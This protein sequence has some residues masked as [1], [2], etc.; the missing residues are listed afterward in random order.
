MNADEPTSKTLPRLPSIDDAYDIFNSLETNQVHTGRFP[1][2]PHSTPNTPAVDARNRSDSYFALATPST[3]S[4]ATQE[5]QT[6]TGPLK[7]DP[8]VL[9][10]KL[11]HNFQKIEQSLYAQ[12]ARTPDGCL[13]DVR[14]AFL[15]TGKGTR[16][17]LQAWQKKHLGVAKSKVVGGLIVDEPEWWGK[18]WH[19]LPGVNVV[20]RDDDWGSII[21]HTLSTTNYQL[22]LANLSMIRTGSGSHASPTP[23]ES[24][25]SSFFSVATGY[26]LFSSS[27]KNHPDP[28]QEDVVWNEP[29]HF[30]AVIS[31]KDHPR[32]P[33]SILSIRDVLRQ[34][35]NTDTPASLSSTTSRF[36]APSNASTA[37]IAAT[38]VKSKPDVALNMEFADGTLVSAPS[39]AAENVGVLILQHHKSLDNAGTAIP[40]PVSRP[41][42]IKSVASSGSNVEPPAPT[43][44]PQLSTAAS[45]ISTDTDKSKDT[46]KKPQAAKTA[47]SVSSHSVNGD[48]AEFQPPPPPP[49]DTIKR[50]SSDGRAFGAQHVATPSTSST[51]PSA[52]KT[53]PAT[54]PQSEA[55]TPSST[56]SGFVSNLAHGINSAM[57]LVIP[58]RE[59][60]S[61]TSTPST[62]TLKKHHAL[63]ADI[64]TFDERPHIKYDWTV[65]KR[66]KFSCT[67]YYAKQFDL[68][69]KRY[70]I[71]DTFLTSLSRSMN[72]A[73]TGGKS[74]SNF[75]KTT[76][77]QF[78]IKTLVNAWNVADL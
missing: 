38:P 1:F 8:E 42:S 60:L 12:L 53:T 51:A 34:K 41:V 30:S 69:R 62:S 23:A 6:P 24:T 11:R 70:G 39:D 78:I 74:K 33:T 50:L 63:L 32:D 20:V 52:W 13:N 3:V 17:R 58:G 31:R 26:K 5:S 40:A 19:V 46:I 67:V 21:A 68:L 75:W 10:S 49:K 14:R 59:P 35:A 36:G 73:A 45:V 47:S 18:S 29:E 56:T 76:D 44:E 37:P 77:D 61:R 15:A 2:V 65:G 9:L 4:T 7:D 72:W 66:L 25:P 28:D 54:T 64:T 55:S 71:N 22:E 48:I 27:S 16:K 57:R 43:S